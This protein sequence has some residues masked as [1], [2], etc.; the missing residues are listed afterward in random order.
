MATRIIRF[1]KTVG[2]TETE[3]GNLAPP[4]G[5]KW[6]I[7]EL[8]TFSP[9]GGNHVIYRAYFDTELYHEIDSRIT[10]AQHPRAHIVGID[11]AQ[12]HVYRITAQ[13]NAANVLAMMEVVLEESPLG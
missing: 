1:E 10:P 11:V 9:G 12:P 4:S 13:A 5:I 2:T 8:R 7:V 3:L 6:T